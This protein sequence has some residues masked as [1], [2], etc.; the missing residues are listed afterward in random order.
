MTG[1]IKDLLDKLIGNIK[2]Y[3][4]E[5]QSIKIGYI[6]LAFKKKTGDDLRGVLKLKDK[7]ASYAEMVE[8]DGVSELSG[9][10]EAWLDNRMHEL[11]E[12][13]VN[14]IMNGS[15][16]VIDNVYE[17]IMQDKEVSD[18]LAAR[19]NEVVSMLEELRGAKAEAGDL[20][21]HSSVETEYYLEY[22]K[23]VYESISRIIA[24]TL[25]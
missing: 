23:L 7:V 2:K 6:T 9:Y 16:D 17:L 14:A 15:D 3:R 1:N 4:G 10:S 11:F 19:E 22:C 25:S 20:L 24:I 18:L 21:E 8:S 13:D 5:L 12:S